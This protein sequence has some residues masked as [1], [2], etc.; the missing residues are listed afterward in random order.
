MSVKWKLSDKYLA[1]TS[2]IQRQE[3][4]VLIQE[5]TTEGKEILTISEYSDIEQD[6]LNR[7]IRCVNMYDQLLIRISELEN[8]LS[9]LERKEEV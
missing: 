4:D 8:L 9:N 7:I 6:D 5:D 3:V 1:C 2:C